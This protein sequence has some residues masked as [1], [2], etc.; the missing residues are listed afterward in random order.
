MEVN[1]KDAR[2]QISSL[3]DRIQAGEEILIVRRGKKVAR[4]VPVSG[5]EKRLP[6]LSRFRASIKVKGGSLS[7]DVIE[8][9]GMERY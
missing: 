6:D 9:R 8:G 3:L 5:P 4:L 2:N 7:Q 1:A